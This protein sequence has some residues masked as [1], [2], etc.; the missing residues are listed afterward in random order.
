MTGRATQ[1]AQQHVRDIP[2]ADIPN[3]LQL[4]DSRVAKGAENW[5]GG[6]QSS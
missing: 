6:T 1:R 2:R 5:L 3:L 4:H